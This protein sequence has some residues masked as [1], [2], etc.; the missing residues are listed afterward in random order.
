M[1]AEGSDQGS[2]VEKVRDI[3]AL[4]LLLENV[5]QIQHAGFLSRC[6]CRME[7]FLV[8]RLDR[9]DCRYGHERH[10][11]RERG[12]EAE[13]HVMIPENGENDDQNDN[14]ENYYFII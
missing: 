2:P 10:V 14:S 13:I 3:E 4:H 8:W 1:M 9:G 5:Q 7:K 6:H 11:D 12:L